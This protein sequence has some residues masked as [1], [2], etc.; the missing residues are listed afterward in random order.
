MFTDQEESWK[1]LQHELLLLEA[2]QGHDARVAGAGQLAHHRLKVHHPRAASL[3]STCVP[4]PGLRDLGL[5]VELVGAA[6][7]EV[8]QLNLSLV[9]EH[10]IALEQLEKVLQLAL[11]LVE[12]YCNSKMDLGRFSNL[13][14]ERDVTMFFLTRFCFD[15]N[16]ETKAW[17]NLFIFIF[18]RRSKS[19]VSF[20]GSWRNAIK[21]V[22]TGVI[23]TKYG[24]C[25]AWGGHDFCLR[26][27]AQTL[28]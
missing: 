6:L 13:G 8:L 9:E 14:L 7:L 11:N 24:M 22:F 12:Q 19:K 10:C 23:C 28:D 2:E 20:C 27:L 26:K 16:I 21:T 1:Q 18:G 17:S 4:G 5:G 3:H 15:R 25:I